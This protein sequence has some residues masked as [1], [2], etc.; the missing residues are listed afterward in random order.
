MVVPTRYV[1]VQFCELARNAIPAQLFPRIGGA[2][3]AHR[4]KLL[5]GF[6]ETGEYR[7]KV[8]RCAITPPPLAT[9]ISA[10]PTPAVTTTG[11]P[12]IIASAITLPKF[13]ES[14]GS[15]NKRAPPNSTSLSAPVI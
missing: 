9:T 12:R 3:R 4:R 10:A 7:S 11:N 5:I 13:S 8:V 15:T 2:G 14:D 1:A 6:Q